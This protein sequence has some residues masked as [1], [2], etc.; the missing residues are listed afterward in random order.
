MSE[1]EQHA[2]AIAGRLDH[3]KVGFVD[4]FTLIMAICSVLSFL[5]QAWRFCYSSQTTSTDMQ[6]ELKFQCSKPGGRERILRQMT[7]QIKRKSTETLSKSQAR[8]IAEATLDHALTVPS[9]QMLSYADSCGPLAE[10]EYQHIVGGD[11]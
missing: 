3:G 2:R 1:T 7:R 8:K 4:P 5:M 6:G 10:C 11:E 9:D